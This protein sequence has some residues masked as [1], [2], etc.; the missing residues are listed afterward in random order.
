MKI[1]IKEIENS[2]LNEA[3]SIAGLL[4]TSIDDKTLGTL[5]IN[6]RK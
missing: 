3:A 6:A 5:I 4:G 2:L 1:N